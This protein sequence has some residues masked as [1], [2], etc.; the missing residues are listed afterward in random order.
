MTTDSRKHLGEILRERRIK[1]LLTL[2]ELSLDT[3]VS[4]SHLG[5]IEQGKRFPSARVLHKIARPL[6]F[7][8]DKLFTLAGFLSPQSSAPA[9]SEA[10]RSIRRL[11]PNVAG[12]LAAEPVAVQRTVIGILAILRAMS[13]A[14]AKENLQ[15]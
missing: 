15:Q 1:E 2:K 14:M 6:G 5:R 12:V 13:K 11:D 8:E 7:E 3:G 9:E 4:Q 10:N